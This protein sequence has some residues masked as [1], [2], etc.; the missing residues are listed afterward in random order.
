MSFLKSLGLNHTIRNGLGILVD[1]C[2]YGGVFLFFGQR[3]ALHSISSSALEFRGLELKK[4][5][6]GS[7]FM[8]F[9]ILCGH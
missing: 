2:S 1:T 9:R 4:F 6:G 5:L 3:H 8:C 7:T